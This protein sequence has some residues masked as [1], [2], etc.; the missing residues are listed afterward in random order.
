MSKDFTI[1]TVYSF[2]IMKVFIVPLGFLI[3]MLYSNTISSEMFGLLY[4]AIAF[5]T[6]ISFFTT[7]GINASF[8]YFMG[9]YRATNNKNAVASLFQY[10]L[11]IKIIL[12]VIMSSLVYLTSD[13]IA[14]YYFQNENAQTILLI[15]LFYF[16]FL[17]LYDTLKSVFV[18]HQL[19]LYFQGAR[20]IEM[21]SVLTLSAIFFLSVEQQLF[22]YY[23]LAWGIGTAIS[24]C[25]YIVLTIYK[26][27]Y[28]FKYQPFNKS[29][30][31]QY[32]KYAMAMF[33]TG[34]SRQIIGKTDVF[35]ITFFLSLS[36]VAYYTNA[37]S[38]IATFASLVTI[39]SR[40]LMPL[41]AQYREEGK[42]NTL[43]TMIITLYKQVL[44]FLIPISLIFYLFSDIILSLIFGEE[45]KNA[46]ITLSILSL[47]LMIRILMTFNIA[48]LNG[49]GR[50][51]YLSKIILPIA[52]F[53]LI[54]NV[55]IVNYMGI[56]GVALITGI[57]WTLIL[58]F[59]YKAVHEE[60]QLKIPYIN[61]L[62]IIASISIF[63]VLT[64]I[65]KQSFFIFNIYIT[66]IIIL[67]ISYATYI[68][69]GYLLKI[70]TIKELYIFIPTKLQPTI[71]HYHQTYLKFLK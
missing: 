31:N 4:S 55:L 46:A 23:A 71:K 7:G 35:I 58:A 19:N 59:T 20:F 67:T 30:F 22:F 29:L 18:A 61:L 14:T 6:L 45:Y 10:N 51:L 53:N 38:L 66:G 41:F 13:I 39:L 2:Y 49:L 63:I 33:A 52:L 1:N 27:P 11:S 54:G 26:F 36:S 25:I 17:K 57:S 69:L 60:L 28:L 68:V 65:L 70:F 15:F 21:F 42:I 43:Q 37:L 16:I 9:K 64:H 40:P 3:K 50:A 62:K 44:F 24:L 32:I 56:E 12:I 8:E 48:F 5:F 34:I 47:F